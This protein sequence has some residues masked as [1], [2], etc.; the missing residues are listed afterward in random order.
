MDTPIYD[1]AVEGEYE[2]LKEIL[3]KDSTQVAEIDEYGFTPLHG[4]ASEDYVEV[5]QLLLEHGADVRA[6]NDEGVTPLHLA[7]T[8]E[9]ASLFL[10]NG[11]EIDALTHDGITPLN[12]AASEYRSVD[13]IQELLRRGANPNILNKY[14]KTAFAVAQERN[15]LEILGVLNRYNEI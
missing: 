1:L 15:A 11:A 13:L 9:M 5:A 4:V 10:D 8:A 3:S 2:V 14:G 6:V 12:L 7:S